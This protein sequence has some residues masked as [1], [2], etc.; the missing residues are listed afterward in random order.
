MKI[1][2]EISLIIVLFALLM[3]TPLVIS[4]EILIGVM[5]M[6]YLYFNFI[7]AIIIIFGIVYWIKI[8]QPKIFFNQIDLIF[9]AFLVYY[10]INYYSSPKPESLKFI[11]F[12]GML[13]LYWVI[14]QIMANNRDKRWLVIV[15]VCTILLMA[16]IQIVWIALQWMGK[17]HSFNIYHPVTGSFN[18]PSPMAIYLSMHLPLAVALFLYISQPSNRLEYAAKMFAFITII[19]ISITLPITKS[20]TA[21]IVAILGV[22]C[23]IVY[24][25]RVQ[26]YWQKIANTS[27]RKNGIISLSL[28]LV[29]SLGLVLYYFKKDSADGRLLIWKVGGS[30]IETKTLLFGKGFDAVLREYD[31]YQATYFTSNKASTN[32]IMLADQIGCVFNDYLHIIIEFGLVGLLLFVTLFIVIVKK[33]STGKTIIE[34]GFMGAIIIVFVAAFF[35]YPMEVL[36]ITLLMIVSIAILSGLDTDQK[37]YQLPFELKNLKTIAYILGIF[38]MINVVRNQVR[39]YQAYRSAY[40]GLVWHI[41]KAK[42]QQAL[43]LYEK[44]LEN[45]P[46]NGW[47]MM[48]YGKALSETNHRQKSIEVL[49]KA[50]EML[51]DTS[52]YRILGDNY[53]T[54]KRFDEAEQCYQ[55]ASNIVPNKFSIRFHLANLYLLKHDTLKAQKVAIEALNIPVKVPSKY[56]KNIKKQFKRIAELPKTNNLHFTYGK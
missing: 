42:P 4:N 19:L 10:I 35:T 47:I 2:L 6:K 11:V 7:Q 36:P 15:I 46:N 37:V 28:L 20:R 16:N 1:S 54:L 45:L 38:F 39:F 48:Q 50:K 18:N 43:W 8:H 24:L 34:R 49:S 25:P 9:S 14:K 21:W 31:K 56:I 53:C 23:V 55:L 32:E 3:I 40:N 27:T 51:T 30:M 41:V 17:L 12:S 52:L 22:G 13:P 29:L 26:Q 44:S 33:Y 5:T